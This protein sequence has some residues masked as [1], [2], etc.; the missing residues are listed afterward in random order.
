MN[1]IGFSY[2]KIYAERKEPI[3]QQHHISNNIEFIDVKEQ[4]VALMKD[5]KPFKVSYKLSIEYISGTPE[6]KKTHKQAEI[7]FQGSMLIAASAQESQEVLKFWKNK[8]LPEGFRIQLFNII[9][10]KCAI[11]ALQLQEDL[12]IPHYPKL[13]RLA[14]QQD[15][16]LIPTQQSQ[17]NQNKGNNQQKQQ[18]QQKSHK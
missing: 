3:A 10:S 8:Q 16:Q 7:I 9:L 14:P 5:A 4:P 13:P 1:I 11:K 15:R 2:D 18:K 12:G 17:Q 6:D